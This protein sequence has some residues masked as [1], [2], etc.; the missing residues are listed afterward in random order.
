[1]CSSKKWGTGGSNQKVPDARKARGS[2]D[3][4]GMT[5]AEIPNKGERE[6]VEIMLNLKYTI[7]DIIISTLHYFF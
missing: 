5:L 7:I 2:Q 6:P 3:P 1:V 4:T